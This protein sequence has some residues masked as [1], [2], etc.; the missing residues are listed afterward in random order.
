MESDE[1]DDLA[2]NP[3]EFIRDTVLPRAIPGLANPREAMAIWARLGMAIG[4]GF[5]FM[6]RM[7]SILGKSRIY[8][9]SWMTC[10][11]LRFYR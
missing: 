1:Y 4:K 5:A 2:K 9:G 11:P 3:V 8:A 10:A 6:G 7:A